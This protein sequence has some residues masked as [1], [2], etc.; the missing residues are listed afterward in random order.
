MAP[1]GPYVSAPNPANPDGNKIMKVAPSDGYLPTQ[2]REGR[3]GVGEKLGHLG[4]RRWGL[5]LSS[6]SGPAHVGASEKS[7][8]GTMAGRLLRLRGEV[9]S[10]PQKLG[11]GSRG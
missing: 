4:V 9:M 3:I 11:E 2:M 1:G 10:A 8:G 7:P 5:T 6:P